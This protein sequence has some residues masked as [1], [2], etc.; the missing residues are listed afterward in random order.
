MI[1]LILAAASLACWAGVL[2]APWAAWLCRERLE[3]DPQPSA[4]RKDFTVLMPA[5]DE[6]AVIGETLRALH[7]AAPDAPVIVIDDQSADATADIARGSGLPGLTVIAGTAPPVGWTGTPTSG[8]RREF[9][10]RCNARPMKVARWYRSA[11]SRAGT[12]SRH[13]GWRRRSCISSSCCIRSRW[14]TAK[15]RGWRRRPAA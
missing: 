2:L 14:P 3:A 6:A 1:M 10:R 13:A 7:D 11:P 8:S 4:S 9:W 15:V 12:A 5:R